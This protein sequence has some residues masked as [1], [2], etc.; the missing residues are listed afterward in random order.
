[1]TWAFEPS[2]KHGMNFDSPI[3][4]LGDEAM[5]LSRVLQTWH[6]LPAQMAEHGPRLPEI[7]GTLAPRALATSRLDRHPATVGQA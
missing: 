4:L 7:P 1:M 2:T 5:I 3:K 6:A